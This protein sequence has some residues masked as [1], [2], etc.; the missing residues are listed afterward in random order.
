MGTGS[1]AMHPQPGAVSSLLIALIGFVSG[2]LLVGTVALVRHPPVVGE[3]VRAAVSDGTP[4]QS[5]PMANTIE[6][7]KYWPADLQPGAWPYESKAP[8][9]GAPGLKR[10]D[11]FSA[12]E[13][14]DGAGP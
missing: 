4:Q 3:A 2:A 12:P 1:M 13:V 9:R 5:V 11:R 14:S 8:V 7:G 6:G 10:P